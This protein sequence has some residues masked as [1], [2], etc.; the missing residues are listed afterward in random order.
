M[1]KRLPG[2]CSPANPSN[3]G[4]KS[5]KG[6]PDN[7][8]PAKGFPQ[9]DRALIDSCLAGQP[10]AWDALY[11]TC[12]DS[13]LAAI[14]RQ[15][16]PHKSRNAELVDEIAARVWF[17]LVRNDGELLNRFDP[18]FGVRLTSFLAAIAKDLMS[19]HFRS[20]VRRSRREAVS[21][22]N[23]PTATPPS[24]P[25]LAL[26]EFLSTLTP[27]ERTFYDDVLAKGEQDPSRAG[28]SKANA[29]QLT[30]RIHRKFRREFEHGN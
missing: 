21:L 4:A 2:P 18:A 15:L 22:Q 8:D 19:R 24:L 5:A 29:W 26:E 28:Y 10:A 7:A 3:R 1:A 14:R 23:R 25:P 11:H 9:S 20:E 30:S 27:A 12:H 13:L 16:G 6:G 17:V